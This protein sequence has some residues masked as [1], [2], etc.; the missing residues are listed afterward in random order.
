L[1]SDDPCDTE[2]G[3]LGLVGAAD[4]VLRLKIYQAIESER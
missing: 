2:R 4:T 1:L 3:P